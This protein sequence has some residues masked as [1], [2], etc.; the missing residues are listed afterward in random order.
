MELTL[1]KQKETFHF[2]PPISIEESGLLGLANLEIFNFIFDETEEKNEFELH[3]DESD[4]KLS[5]I[6]MKDKVA[7][8]LGCSDMSPED[9]QHELHGPKNIRTYRKLSIKKNQTNGSYILLKDNGYSP[10]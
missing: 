5:F 3:T 9:A 8:V 2:T 10:F 6:E 7:E 4:E 1:A